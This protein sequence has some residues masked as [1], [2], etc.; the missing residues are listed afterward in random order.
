MMHIY[1]NIVD[2][3]VIKLGTSVMVTSWLINSISF[4]SVL[5]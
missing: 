5:I 2:M 3:D 4:L 1:V